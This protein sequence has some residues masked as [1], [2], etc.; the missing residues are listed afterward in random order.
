MEP[1]NT[2]PLVR[3][4]SSSERFIPAVI[5]IGVGA[6]FFLNNLHILPV[7]DV[8]RYWPAILIAV[9]IIQLVDSAFAAGRTSGGVLVAI[10]SFLLARNL[11]YL[12]FRLRDMWPLILIAIGL[13]M[14]LDRTVFW[15]SRV[16]V[17]VHILN[18]KHRRWREAEV[19]PGLLNEHSVFGGGKRKVNTDN[20]TGGKIDAVFSGYEI[21]LREAMMAAD[22]VVLEANAVFGGIEIRIP[23]TWS[24]VVQGVGVFGAFQDETTQPNVAINPNPKR[25]IIKG[26]A[27][28]GAVEVKN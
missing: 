24:A 27:V 15:N 19:I 1:Q 26:G 16:K 14:L 8:A 20:F 18:E 11:G 10:G 5:L 2:D 7:R 21:D 9:G 28:F 22:S 23:I 17:G 25:L 3:W 12:D 6:L 4:H 13:L